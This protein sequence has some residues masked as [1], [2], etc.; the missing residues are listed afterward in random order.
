MSQ[1]RRGE[2]NSFFGKNHT[3]ETKALLSEIAKN[4]TKSNKPGLEVEV[5]DLETDIKLT[6]PSIRKAAEAVG[7]NI[8][9]LI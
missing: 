5:L 8:G 6:Y 2:N 4:R 9:S 7:A 3:E 1:N